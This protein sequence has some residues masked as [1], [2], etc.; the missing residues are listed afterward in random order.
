MATVMD[1]LIIVGMMLARLGIPILMM[2]LL[3][4]VLNRAKHASV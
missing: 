2:A 4:A 3:A 1:D